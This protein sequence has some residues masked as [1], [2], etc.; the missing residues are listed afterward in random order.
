MNWQKEHQKILTNAND[1]NDYLGISAFLDAPFKPKLPR[2]FADL[3]Q[4]DNPNDPILLQVLPVNCQTKRT[5]FSPEP[6]LDE[7][8]SPVK[9]II[10]KYPNRVLLIASPTCAIACRYCFRQNFTYSQHDIFKNLPDIL[11][12]LDNNT[13]INE[14]IL[15]GGDP[16]SLSDEKLQKLITHLVEIPHLTTMRIHSRTAVVLPSRLTN[17]LAD[18]L[19]NTPLKV[20]LVFHINHS[21]E[22]SADFCKQV[23]KFKPLMLLN[24]SVLLKGVNDRP[25][26]LI[27]LSKQLFKHGILPYYLHQLDKVIGAEYFLVED[28]VAQDLHQNLKDNLSGYLVPKLVRDN[29]N[30]AK[31]WI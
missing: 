30:T 22:M 28:N 18:L 17:T 2:E 9:G 16:L 25:D 24:Q 11:T 6:L 12:Y 10:H 19:I 29:N 5:D 8:Y 15:S 21:Q 26:T 31:D 1:C 20:V 4:K 27:T 14:V 23:K 13:Q 7:G 3:I